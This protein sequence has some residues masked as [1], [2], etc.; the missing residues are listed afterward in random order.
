[1]DKINTACPKC[2]SQ[3]TVKLSILYM[4]GI[5]NVSTKTKSAGIGIGLASGK[6]LGIGVGGA[7]GKTTGTHQTK[8]S[9][10][11]APPENTGVSFSRT[12]VILLVIGFIVWCIC[13]S[14]GSNS[15]TA[16]AWLSYALLIACI[17]Y[18]AREKRTTEYENEYSIWNKKFV[19][20]RCGC[21]FKPTKVVEN[22]Q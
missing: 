15:L 18:L 7:R 5:S 3:D 12:H 1:M 17:Y 20:N 19:C 13:V 22:E 8:L 21:I 4:S 11:A 6:K 2:D 16:L 10:L 9:E 14:A